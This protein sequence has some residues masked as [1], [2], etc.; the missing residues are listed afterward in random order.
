MS[1]TP[2][3]PMVADLG[4]GTGA[5]MAWISRRTQAEIVGITVSKA[6]AAAAAS[7]FCTL[8]PPVVGSYDS[9]NDLRRMS[10]GRL[11][12]GAYMIESFVHAPD[13]EHLLRAIAAQTRP[14]G[15]LVICDD[16]PSERLA[17]AMASGSGADRSRFLAERF[18]AGW[19]IQT[20]LSPRQIAAVATRAGWRLVRSED[21]SG[22]V[23]TYRPRDLVARVGSWFATALGLRGSWW[24]NVTGGS[25]LQ[26]LIHRRAVR[27]RLITLQRVA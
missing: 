22:F 5:S 9:V 1:G 19:H 21:L 25:A 2:A 6:Q 26:R 14:G 4:C 23:A 8:T 27:Y 16:L 17:R 10:G 7:R 13:A 24:D 3:H 15:S 20:F 18:R 11:L 12:S